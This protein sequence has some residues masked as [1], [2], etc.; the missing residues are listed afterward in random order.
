MVK[1]SYHTIDKVRNSETEEERSSGMPSKNS[2]RGKREGR[3]CAPEGRYYNSSLS[4]P[5]QHFVYDLV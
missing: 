4:I 1:N 5:F 3:G 2:R